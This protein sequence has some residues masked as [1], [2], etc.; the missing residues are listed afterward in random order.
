M[1]T[2]VKTSASGVAIFTAL[3]ATQSL[4]SLSVHFGSDNLFSMMVPCV[5]L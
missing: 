5:V 4:L 2:P 1:F 3:V